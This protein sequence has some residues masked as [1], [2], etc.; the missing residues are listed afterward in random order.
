MIHDI[1]T[2]IFSQVAVK[3]LRFKSPLDGYDAEDR[4]AKVNNTSFKKRMY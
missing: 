1:T 4:S 2:Y 3:A